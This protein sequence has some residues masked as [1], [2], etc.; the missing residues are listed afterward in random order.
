MQCNAADEEGAARNALTIEDAFLELHQVVAGDVLGEGE[1]DGHVVGDADLINGQIRVRR[2]D[3]AARK[4]HPLARQ[5]P[6]EPA[7]LALQPLHKSPA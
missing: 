3:C 1:H 4:I 2:D 7:L 6:P 5:I